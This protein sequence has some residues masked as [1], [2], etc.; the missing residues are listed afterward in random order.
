MVQAFTFG[1]ASVHY[2]TRFV[3]TAKY[4]RD[5]RAGRFVGQS[6]TTPAPGGWIANLG[7]GH[8][9]DTSGVNAQVWAG[10][11]YALE[12]ANPAHRMD[13][14]TL[15]T[16]GLERFGLDRALFSAHPKQDRRRGAW[17]HFGLGVGL[18]ELFLSTLD[19]AGRATDARRSP[20][21]I[22]R[23]D[24]ISEGPVAR[25][26]LDHHTPLSFH[27]SWEPTGGYAAV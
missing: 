21:A 16:E 18:R 23:A 12:D 2:Q 17:V 11:L 13:P 7:V 5:E 26:L 14:E 8:F 1:D 15:A 22:L 25:V 4:E 10:K 20:L 3:R 6:W 24:A 27:G 9:P 19:A